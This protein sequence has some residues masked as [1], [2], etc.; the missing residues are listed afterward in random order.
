MK[1]KSVFTFG[2]IMTMALGAFADAD[3]TLIT[4]STLG[5]NRPD[6]YADGTIVKDGEWYALA[7]SKNETFG[8]VKSDGTPMV[9]GDRIL[10]AAPL[11]KKGHCPWVVFQVDSQLVKKELEGGNFF[12]IMLDTRGVDAVP[13]KRVEG[14][15]MP[16]LLNGAIETAAKAPAGGGSQQIDGDVTGRKWAESAPAIDESI[17]PTVSDLHYVGKKVVGKVKGLQPTIRYNIYFGKDIKS[18]NEI[19]LDKPFMCPA[20]PEAEVEFVLDVAGEG[21]GYLQVRRQSISGK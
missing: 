15:N 21:D 9:D 14:Q 12:V 1:M 5:S 8:G 4:F 18:V 13:S 19:A 20:D 7:W 6:L 16:A 2:L 3:N 17:L 11:A 10:L